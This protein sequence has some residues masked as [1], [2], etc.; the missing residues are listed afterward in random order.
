MHRG[1]IE[2][3]IRKE[4]GGNNSNVF[5]ESKTDILLS[6]DKIAG[7]YLGPLVRN[8][9]DRYARESQKQNL[10]DGKREIRIEASS[11]YSPITGSWLK[12][13]F[14]LFGKLKQENVEVE[15]ERDLE[16]IKLS[17][18]NKSI[19]SLIN[20]FKKA[21]GRQLYYYYSDLTPVF[22]IK[23]DI[24]PVERFIDTYKEAINLD[25]AV[26]KDRNPRKEFCL[27]IGK[28]LLNFGMTCTNKDSIKY[29]GLVD[30]FLR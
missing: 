13:G 11:Y 9:P 24:K 25:E 19:V 4:V 6:K 5:S 14:E 3:I 27:S 1:K 30:E 12:R 10:S 29:A 28:N 18:K 21:E 22:W 20:D 17:P 26:L 16:R 15:W 8:H 23:D 7:I 2:E